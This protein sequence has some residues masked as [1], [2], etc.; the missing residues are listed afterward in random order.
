MSQTKYQVFVSDASGRSIWGMS[1]SGSGDQIFGT[2]ASH[3]AKGVYV[4]RMDALG[5]V[6]VERIVVW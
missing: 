1:G 6:R 3:L 5:L 4:G 2:D